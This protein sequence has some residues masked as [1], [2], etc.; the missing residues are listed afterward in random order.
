MQCRK[1][2][3]NNDKSNKRRELILF[4]NLKPRNQLIPTNSVKSIIVELQHLFP[5]P[6]PLP[7]QKPPEFTPLPT[8]FCFPS[9]WIFRG[10]NDGTSSRAC[11]D[12]RGDPAPDATLSDI[13][14]TLSFLG[15]AKGDGFSC[16][17]NEEEFDAG[18]DPHSEC[19]EGVD[20][21]LQIGLGADLQV[22]TQI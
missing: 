17:E 16:D 9:T 11:G 14:F 13:E 2:N 7:S 4:V 12:E 18:D 20:A 19:C 10:Q 3:H 1:D 5:D 21:D 15:E 8:P 22:Y 6:S